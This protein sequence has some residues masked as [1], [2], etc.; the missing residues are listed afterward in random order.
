AIEPAAP[1][2]P[3]FAVS[4]FLVVQGHGAL[5]A[6]RLWSANREACNDRGSPPRARPARDPSMGLDFR[7]MPPCS[8]GPV[9]SVAPPGRSGDP[10]GSFALGGHRNVPGSSAAPLRTDLW[11]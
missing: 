8:S 7:P 1:E 5:S 4:E 3:S 2:I 11:R 9:S 10:R 6:A